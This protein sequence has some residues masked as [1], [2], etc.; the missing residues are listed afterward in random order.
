MV[1]LVFLYVVSL[2]V[3]DPINDI[4]SHRVTSFLMGVVPVTIPC[5]LSIKATIRMHLK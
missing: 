4:K 1:K 5:E 3:T 2:K